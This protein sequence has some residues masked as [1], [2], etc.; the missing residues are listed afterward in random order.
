MSTA[1]PSNPDVGQYR[2]LLLSVAF[3]LLG[4]THDAEDMVQEAYSRWYAMNSQ[5]QSLIEVPQAWLV[6]V[7]SRVCLDQLRSARVRR[8]AY[9]GDWLPEPLPTSYFAANFGTDALAGG[10]PIN[11]VTL[12]ESVSTAL[13][14]LLEEVTPA[15]RVTLILHDVFAIPYKEIAEIVGRSSDACRQLA[16]SA[17]RHIN[18]ERYGRSSDAGAHS[19]VVAAFKKACSS[20]RLDE[21]IDTLDP[22][23]VV[24]VDGGGKT[25]AALRPVIGS[26]K[27]A[28]FARGILVKQDCAQLVERS[29][30][31]Q[32]GL[33]LLSGDQ[34]VRVYSFDVVDGKIVRIW[35]VANP[36]KLGNWNA[37]A[38]AAD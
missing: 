34:V 31:G 19:A 28:R 38:D 1:E 36:D 32:S 29:V 30:N 11:E 3:R 15:E 22:N 14:V 23:V 10:D 26:D 16:V 25:R 35:I 20:G 12:D 21:L 24:R 4:S 8:E 37:P 27:V 18:A 13:L 7:T 6:Q 33:L 17:R 2:K 5:A 9:V